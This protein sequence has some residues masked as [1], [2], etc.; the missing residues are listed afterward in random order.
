MGKNSSNKAERMYG[1]FILLYPRDYRQE[2]GEEMKYI[3]SRSIKDTYHEDSKNGIFLFWTRTVLDT[4]KSLVIQHVENQKGGDS[5]SNKVIKEIKKNGILRV[6]II[7]GIILSIPLIAMQFSNEVDWDSTDFL[8]MGIL[9]S[10]IGLT[11]ELIIKKLLNKKYWP[12][13][14]VILIGIFLF[15]WAELAVGIVGS[16]FAGN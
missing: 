16:P 14:A 1:I 4:G 11:Y 6:F 13:A 3:F 12:L 7:T 9:I 5:M 10:G 15:I 2:F 8:V